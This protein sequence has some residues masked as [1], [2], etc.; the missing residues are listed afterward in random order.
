MRSLDKVVI[1][2]VYQPNLTSHENLGN[3]FKLQTRLGM[4][5][6]PFVV[7]KYVRHNSVEMGFML[8]QG[9][10]DTVEQ[11]AQQYNQDTITLIDHDNYVDIKYIKTNDIKPIGQLIEVDETKAELIGDFLVLPRE[12][13]Y[14][15]SKNKLTKIQP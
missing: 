1:F 6:I 12:N 8:D 15:V 3:H 2:T 9:Y 4:Q 10:L 11:L 7:V 14:L 5:D 13:K